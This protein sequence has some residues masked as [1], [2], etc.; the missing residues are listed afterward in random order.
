MF[1]HDVHTDFPSGP[2]D[3]AVLFSKVLGESVV[4]RVCQCTR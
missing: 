1:E 2:K 4:A 3:S